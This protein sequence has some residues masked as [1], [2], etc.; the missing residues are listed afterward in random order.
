MGVKFDADVIDRMRGLAETE[1][2]TY[3]HGR[4]GGP[5]PSLSDAARRLVGEALDARQG[6]A[7]IPLTEQGLAWID[8]E[9][10]REGV[11]RD[12]MVKVLLSEAQVA[13]DAGRSTTQARRNGAQRKD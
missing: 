13:R 8:A 1:G 5:Q 12:R 2:W 10:D 11:T 3:D 7:R 4:G 6:T 9:A